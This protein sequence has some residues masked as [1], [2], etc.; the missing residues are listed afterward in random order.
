MAE[1]CYRCGSPGP[2][3]SLQGKLYCRPCCELSFRALP[4]YRRV[5]RR[6]PEREP[7]GFGRRWTDV[8][9]SRNSDS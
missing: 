3:L 4:R 7:R 8:L 5:E 6:N 2:L 1:S 9:V